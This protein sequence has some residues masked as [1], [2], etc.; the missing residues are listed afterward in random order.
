MDGLK[1]KITDSKLMITSRT[2]DADKIKTMDDV[3][4]LFKAMD[5]RVQPHVSNYSELEHLFKEEE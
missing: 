2:I 1:G 4:L 3:R 5:M